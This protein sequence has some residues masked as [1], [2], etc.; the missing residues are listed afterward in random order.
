M[1]KQPVIT[2]SITKCAALIGV[3]QVSIT[4]W[5]K[6]E[7]FPLKQHGLGRGGAAVEM[8]AAIKWYA[9][10]E[11]RKQLAWATAKIADLEGSKSST[12]TSHDDETTK[13]TIARR[14]KTELETA[15]MS[16]KLVD[17]DEFVVAASEAMQIIAMRDD[18]M[19]GRLA[20]ELGAMTDAGEIRKKLLDELRDNRAGAALRLQSWAGMV[21]GGAVAATT[22]E[23]DA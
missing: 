21:A 12:V 11:V 7:G 15:V 19:A 5:I 4:N 8:P 2:V 13:L 6:K 17:F 18:G 1:A 16:G 10:R 22:A 3:S 20:A 9:E 23:P 14:L